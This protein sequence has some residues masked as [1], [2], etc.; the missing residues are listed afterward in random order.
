MIEMSRRQLGRMLLVVPV[1]APA[2]ADEKKQEPPSPQA[3]F[4]AAQ[5]VG[6][7]AQERE[8]LKKSISDFDKSLS[9]VRDFN[10]PPDVP[11]AVR[12]AAMKSK[13]R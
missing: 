1:V 5:E 7:S 8:A 13:R 4:I 2:L 12:F 3:E 6:L 10:L 11:P 9:A